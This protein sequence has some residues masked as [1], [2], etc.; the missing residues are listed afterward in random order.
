ML[1]AAKGA[2]PPGLAYNFQP[3]NISTTEN[4][5]STIDSVSDFSTRRGAISNP[6]AVYSPVSADLFNISTV[7]A[8]TGGFP[9]SDFSKFTANST[10]TNAITAN[11]TAVNSTV[12]STNATAKTTGFP[13]NSFTTRIVPDSSISPTV[14][15]VPTLSPDHYLPEGTP[16]D[17][18]LSRLHAAGGAI[19][20]HGGLTWADVFK[21]L[22]LSL[23]YVLVYA[24]LKEPIVFA[25]MVLVLIPFLAFLVEFIG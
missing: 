9:S 14:T 24:M 13:T 17:F 11:I 2:G 4:P 15:S 25:S 12:T 20:L 23:A 3:I 8:T 16:L 5:A 1:V 21:P 10:V 6:T 19:Q 18:G 22:W 7:N